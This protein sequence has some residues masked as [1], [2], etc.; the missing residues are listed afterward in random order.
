MKAKIN[1][2]DFSLTYLKLL[3]FGKLIYN[4]D[5]N[6]RKIQV[7]NIRPYFH[8]SHVKKQTNFFKASNWVSI[9][10]NQSKEYMNSTNEEIKINLSTNCLHKRK[11]I[12]IYF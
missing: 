4:K 11:M 2:P 7:I 9:F 3:N 10:L 6:S 1:I 5:I 12:K 8:F